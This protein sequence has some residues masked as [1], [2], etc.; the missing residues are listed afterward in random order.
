[1]IFGVFSLSLIFYKKN[2]ENIENYKYLN[3]VFII[4]LTLIT[5]EFLSISLPLNLVD[6]YH[7][8]EWLGPAKNYLITGKIWSGAYFVHG[9]FFDVFNPVIAWK[10]FGKET[11]GSS[12][13]FIFV[14]I[15][16]TKVLSL[17]LTFKI[18]Q[19]IK[20][21]ETTKIVYFALISISILF[22]S[23]YQFGVSRSYIRYTDLPILVFLIFSAEIIL[24]KNKNHYGF[25]IGLISSISLVFTVDRGVYVNILILFLL[26]YFLL[27][28]EF[29]IVIFILL[30]LF[31][32]WALLYILIG[33]KEFGFF[34]KNTYQ[35]GVLFKDFLNSFIYPT[36]FIPGTGCGLASATC[37]GNLRAT[38]GILIVIISGLLTIYSLLVKNENKD[39]SLI[40]YFFII[41]LFALLTYKNALGRSDSAHIRYSMSF[42]IFLICLIFFKNISFKISQKLNS[43]N[44]GLIF[45]VSLSVIL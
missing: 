35:F 34:L 18:A 21:D 23:E 36:P 43:Y 12:R 4:F 31:L 45:V 37:S 5:F 26:A 38:K 17:I 9:A 11:I 16:F 27:R 25:L 2:D 14:L 44:V 6:F 8:G 28:K 40:F 10:I 24:R 33:S 19:F 42:S 39:Y 30:G 13:L 20:S 15:F 41:F 29:Q 32:S 22:L 3:I 1:M 7:E